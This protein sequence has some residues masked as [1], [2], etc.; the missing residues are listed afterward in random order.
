MS[1]SYKRTPVLKCCGDKKYGKR[2][3]NKK[4]RRSDKSVLYRGKQ[5]RKLYESW[6]INDV[7]VFWSKNEAEKSGM[8]DVWKKVVLS[9][10]E[11]CLFDKYVICSVGVAVKMLLLLGRARVFLR[12]EN[13]ALFGLKGQN[14]GQAF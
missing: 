6:D 4:V 3:A 14:K 10:V 2:Q 12:Q 1:R 11:G 5:Y 7:I 8:F 9:K 13:R